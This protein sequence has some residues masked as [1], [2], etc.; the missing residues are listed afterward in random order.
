MKSELL[1][2]FYGK[3][4]V[5][6]FREG[7]I[8]GFFVALPRLTSDAQTESERIREHDPDFTVLTARDV[9]AALKDQREISDLPDSSLLT[10]D[11]AVVITQYGVYSASIELNQISRT[12]ARVL[13]WAP[14]RVVPIPVIDLLAASDYANGVA[15]EDARRTSEPPAIPMRLETEPSVVVAVTGSRSDFEYQLPASPKFFVGRRDAVSALEDAV[16]RSAT[17]VVLNAQSGWGKS[18]LALRFKQLIEDRGGY[19]LVVDTRTAGT[20]RL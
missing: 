3:L 17:V 18:S 15:V 9:V 13:V 20:S 1:S 10:S 14:D 5:R 19:A 8:H 6:R 7:R 11:P 4:T 2:A 12:P 16:H